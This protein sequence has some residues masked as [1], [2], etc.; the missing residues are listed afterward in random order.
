MKSHRLI[1]AACVLASGCA[2]PPTQELFVAPR[3][4]VCL[5][6]DVAA[7]EALYRASTAMHSPAFEAQAGLKEAI[8]AERVRYG[9]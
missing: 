2:L 3:S 4:T 8:A 7:C 5:G 1:L 9:R 6:D